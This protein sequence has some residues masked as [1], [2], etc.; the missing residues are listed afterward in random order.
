MPMQE[1]NT[2]SKLI[3]AA[4]EGLLAVPVYQ[5]DYLWRRDQVVDLL[6]FMLSSYDEDGIQSIPLSPI[7]L[8]TA[9]HPRETFPVGFDGDERTISDQAFLVV[10]GLQRS[11]SLYKSKQGDFDDSIFYD[12][13]LSQFRHTERARQSALDN[14]ELIPV[15]MFLRMKEWNAFRKELNDNRQFDL[16]DELSD[17]RDLIGN[18]QITTQTGR[19]LTLLQQITW[20]NVVNSK[21]TKISVDD[22]IMAVGTKHG[23]D[24][25]GGLQA[26]DDVFRGAGMT[27]QDFGIQE[28]YWKSTRI[29]MILPIMAGRAPMN[30]DKPEFFYPKFN[31]VDNDPELKDL[32]Q[33]SIAAM[34]RIMEKA[35]NI[36]KSLE[37]ERLHK[38]RTHHLLHLVGLSTLVD[39]QLTREQEILFDAMLSRDYSVMAENEIR[40][41]YYD[42]VQ[43]IER[44]L[45]VS[46]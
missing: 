2:V 27:P 33:R 29:L 45:P 18:F 9:K 8:A 37:K 28:R 36:Y 35:I 32:F 39:E 38:L 41:A 44:T 24:I 17:V 30:K 46:N 1:F 42:M 22:Q 23:I 15:S 14:Y 16:I 34:P 10:D 20:F 7:L 43:R 11:M 12:K 40:A 26:V 4:E 19:N 6:N 3:R 25:R 5:R 13:K 21:G 31:M